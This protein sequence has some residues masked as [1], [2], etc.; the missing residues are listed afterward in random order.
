MEGKA[1]QRT[2]VAFRQS[3]REF[4]SR[5]R[6]S[7]EAVYGAAP[8][9]GQSVASFSGSYPKPLVLRMAAGS[10]AAKDGLLQPLSKTCKE[11]HLDSA[12]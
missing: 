2:G 4:V 11:R 3:V 12:P 1:F 7:C 6:P 8:V 10:L 5:C 9:P